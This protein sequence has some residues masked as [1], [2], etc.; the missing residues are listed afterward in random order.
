MEWISVKDRLPE[1]KV[2]VLVYCDDQRDNDR[3]FKAQYKTYGAPY[4]N[5]PDWVV[6]PQNYCCNRASVLD[7]VTHWMPLP[8]EPK[9]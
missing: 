3:I 1:P 6:S 4:E 9:L 2:F 5:D 7:D 8:S